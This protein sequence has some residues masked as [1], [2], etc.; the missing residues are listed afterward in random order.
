MSLRVT[1][2][3]GEGGRYRVPLLVIPGLWSPPDLW[4]GFASYLAHRGWEVSL[5]GL[6]AVSG[7]LASRADA[8]AAHARTLQ[9]RP[10]MLGHDAGAVVALLAARM[11]PAAALVLLHPVEPGS[12][13]ARTLTRRW[14]AV[15]ALVRGRA[16]PPPRGVAA[17]RCFGP[18]DAALTARLVAEP[19]EPVLDVVRGRVTMPPASA[20]ALLV[21]SRDDPLLAAPEALATALGAESAVLPAPGHWAAAGSGWQPAVTAVH[22]WLVLRLGEDLLELYAEAMAE[23]DAENDD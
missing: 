2:V 8:V 23:R 3:P 1:P 5:L 22:R 15:A 12:A 13:A 14:D 11:V 17:T 7:G 6:D 16:L 9:T 18:L 21:G 19:K 20:P 4:R 10:V